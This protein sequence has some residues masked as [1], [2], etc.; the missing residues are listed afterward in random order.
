[1]DSVSMS[2]LGTFADG[3]KLPSAHPMD[4]IPVRRLNFPLEDIGPSDVVWSRSDPQF[5]VFINALGLHVPHFERYLCRALAKGRSHVT[6][7]GLVADVDAIIGQEAQHAKTFLKVNRALAA[8]Y[9]KAALLDQAAADDFR[10]RAEVDDLRRAVGFTAGYETFTFLAGLIILD[11]HDRWFAD[12]HPVMKAIWVWHQVEEVE[13]G[14]VAFEVWQ[15][16]YPGQKGYR[17]RMI[18][19]AL[20]HIAAETMRTYWHMARVEGWIRGPVSAVRQMGYCTLMLSRLL[21]RALPVF[22]RSYHPRRHPLVTDAQ[23]A[24]QVAWRRYALNDGDVLKLDH[25]RMARMMNIADE[26]SVHAA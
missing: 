24:I 21:H 25:A 3:L 10:K 18:V 22:R 5:S 1:M 11:N 20:V 4:D 13:H 17:R 23:N 26:A 2:S 16:L 19:E 6:D 15:N 9:P 14:A 8:R 7:P 12:A